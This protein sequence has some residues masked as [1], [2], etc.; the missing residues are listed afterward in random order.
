MD[1]RRDLHRMVDDV[2]RL[3]RAD[4]ANNDLGRVRRGISSGITGPHCRVTLLSRTSGCGHG[5]GD[6]G[7]RLSVSRIVDRRYFVQ[8]RRGGHPTFERIAR[9]P[10]TDTHVWKNSINLKIPI[11]TIDNCDQLCMVR[12]LA[13]CG[14]KSIAA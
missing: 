2:I 5:L 3:A 12:A 7:K 13:S 10:I 6:Y 1:I 11:V 4:L 14:P 8:N 9:P